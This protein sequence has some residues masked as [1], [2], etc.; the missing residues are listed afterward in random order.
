MLTTTA[1]HRLNMPSEENDEKSANNVLQLSNY[2]TDYLTHDLPF[3]RDIEIDIS[4]E[5]EVELNNS[6]KTIYFFDLDETLWCYETKTLYKYARSIL[7]HLSSNGHMIFLISYNHAAYKVLEAYDLVKYFT[8]GKCGFRSA[9]KSTLIDDIIKKYKISPTHPMRFI[10]DQLVNIVDIGH[11]S[12]KTNITPVH[13]LEGADWNSV[14]IH[15]QPIYSSSALYVPSYIEDTLPEALW[16]SFFDQYGKCNNDWDIEFCECSDDEEPT[17]P[18]DNDI[19]AAYEE[20][21]FALE[22]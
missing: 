1:L 7:H 8:G 12:H 20:I 17:T 6:L 15:D 10:D 13:V 14:S 19:Q 16:L 18:I 21:M 4:L 9:L 3:A 22:K 5:T 11:Y 2:L